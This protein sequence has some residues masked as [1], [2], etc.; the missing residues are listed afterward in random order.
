MTEKLIVVI[1]CYEP[2][3]EFEEYAR[4]I[5]EIAERLIVVNDGSGE[6]YD[7]IFESVAK[8]P[9]VTYL[10]YGENHGKGYALKMA[11]RY[12]AENFSDE[13][14][15]ITA[16]CDGQHTVEDVQRLYRASVSHKSA[17][18]LGSRNFDQSNVPKRSA[19]GNKSI[20][21]IYRLFCGIKLYDTQTGLRAFSV[22]LGKQLASVRGDRF[23]YEMS[24]L[25][26]TK[27][28]NINILELPIETVYPDDPRDHVSH[29]KSIRDSAR[30]LGVVLRNVGLYILSAAVACIVD[31]SVFHIFVTLIFPVENAALTL[32]ATAIARVSSSVINFILNYKMVFGGASKRS[33]YRYYL[34]W[35]FQLGASYGLTIL[36]RNT[37][38]WHLTLTKLMCDLALGIMSYGIQNTWVFEKRDKRR[39]FGRYARFGKKVVR[40]LLP[41]YRANVLP[42]DEPVVYV[43]RHLNLRGPVKALSQINFDVH[44]MVFSPF[45]DKKTCYRQFADYTFTERA[46]KKKKKY[47]IKAYISS[48]LVA[49]LIRS[50]RCVP[51]YRDMVN[52]L[53]MFDYSME[54]LGRGES[55]IV[56]PDVEYTADAD[57]ESEIYE[58]FLYLGQIYKSKFGRD[59]KFIPI[60]INE[61][62]RTIDEREAITVSSYRTD[63]DKASNYIKAAINGR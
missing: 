36:F 50:M 33:I 53:K 8:S 17:L 58:G 55:L 13:D 22:R 35:F 32:A 12:C 57:H 62:S 40:L 61:S 42:C 37:V 4:K 21:M 45:F 26:Y 47:N 20:R 38:G 56:F 23:E 16:D 43:C 60:Y 24:V 59:L 31:I 41:K 2:P 34:L 28:H 19:F 30:I 14:V 7:R 52:M 46:G 6:K 63:K 15:I 27:R 44:A 5:C 49:P 48:R 29:Y 10:S 1:P 25:I 54:Y 18:M 9:N 11:L 39:F 3:E 51:V